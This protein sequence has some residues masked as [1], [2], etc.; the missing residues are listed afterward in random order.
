MQ[1]LLMLAIVLTLTACVGLPHEF[2]SAKAPAN[3]Q[4]KCVDLRDP[5]VGEHY[6]SYV[7]YTTDLYY[8]C[9]MRHDALINYTEE[10]K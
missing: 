2:Q 10:V 5:T 3:A 1:K 7:A 4:A 6:E 8:D 9:A